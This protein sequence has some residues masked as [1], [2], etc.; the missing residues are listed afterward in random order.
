MDAPYNQRLF[1]CKRSPSDTEGYTPRPERSFGLNIVQGAIKDCSLALRAITTKGCSDKNLFSICLA[2][3]PFDV[4]VKSPEGLRNK[5]SGDPTS[6]RLELFCSWP[7]RGNGIMAFYPFGVSEF[8]V[9]SS[10]ARYK[11]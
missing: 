2:K 9:Q 10:I 11:A 8:R 6:L 4:D 1:G 7:I 5:Q 3:Q